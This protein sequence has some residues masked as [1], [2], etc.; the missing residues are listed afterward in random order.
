MGKPNDM[1]SREPEAVD[2]EVGVSLARAEWRRHRA[3][4]RAAAVGIAFLGLA[5]IAFG[6][7]VDRPATAR[8][9]GAAPEVRAQVVAVAESPDQPRRERSGIAWSVRVTWTDGA[10]TRQGTGRIMADSKPFEPGDAVVIYVHAGSGDVSLGDDRE[11]AL[12]VWAPVTVGTLLAAAAGVAFVRTRRWAG[13]EGV[14][15]SR[16]P[17]R[18][19]VDSVSGRRL[20]LG[21]DY[22]PATGGTLLLVRRP[23]KAQPVPGDQL[24][25]WGL[26]LHR[27]GPLLALDPVDGSWWVGNGYC[28]PPVGRAVHHRDQAVDTSG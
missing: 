22:R 23:D 15:R 20:R 1:R 4:L 11:G 10:E 25:V 3:N 18:L 12:R 26:T 24:D 9:F 8:A 21:I 5:L 13:L 28:P 16:P 6:L 17:A 27:S 7:L 19:T 14:I 2:D